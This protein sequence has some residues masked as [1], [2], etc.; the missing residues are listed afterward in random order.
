MSPSANILSVQVLDDFRAA[1]LRYSSDVSQSLEAAAMEIQRTLAWLAERVAYW[2]AEVRRLQEVVRQAR[3]AL[4][5][6]R[7]SGS[8]D[9]SGRSR[10]PDCGRYERALQEAERQLREAEMQLR[11]AL[12]W[13]QRVQ[14]AADTYQREARRMADQIH[15]DLPKATAM[16]SRTTAILQGYVAMNAPTGSV[17]PSVTVSPFIAAGIAAASIA[18]E[19]VAFAAP[20]AWVERGIQNVPLAQIDLSESWVK[21]VEDF[22]KVPHEEMVEGMHKLEEVVRPAVENG[23]DGDYFMRLDQERGLD[24]AHGYQKIYEAFYGRSDPIRLEKSG[25]T[26]TVINGYHRLLVAREAGLSNIPARIVEQTPAGNAAQGD[27]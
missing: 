14:Q 9:K 18:S 24:Y 8:K 25:D 22:H 26:Y 21:S 16:L 15:N 5:R 6:C 23:A 7:S 17:A 10:E 11:T 1:L 12:M 3:E 13:Q 4:Q 2:Q 27:G 20:G 19:P